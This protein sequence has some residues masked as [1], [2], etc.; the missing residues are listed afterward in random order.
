[1]ANSDNPTGL[2]PRYFEDGSPYAGQVEWYYV[3]S[4]DGTA[5]Y[6]GDTVKLAGGADSEGVP[7]VTKA[8]SGD[9]VVGV[10]VAVSAIEGA[11]SSG[12]DSEV[13]RP[14]SQERYVQVAVDPDILY[15]VQEDS[16][17]STLAAADVGLNAEIIDGGGDSNTGLSGIELDSSSAATTA[18]HDLQIRRLV[19]RP[20]NEIGDNAKWL[21]KLN[22][23]QYA[24]GSTGIS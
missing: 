14:A 3:P 10:M 8:S 23:H 2:T 20:D 6:L 11:D 4:T 24:N 17:T 7:S 5:I 19:R 9:A 21:V 16:D 22:N 18:G 13:Y 1:M 12:R 15:E